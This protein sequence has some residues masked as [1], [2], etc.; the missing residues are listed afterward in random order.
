MNNPD[1]SPCLVVLTAPSG[2]GKTTIANQIMAKIPG[3]RFSVSATT[4]PRRP[5]EED[6]THYRFISHQEFQALIHSG[7][8]LEHEEVYPGRLY[9]TL[10][11]ELEGSSAE[12]PILLDI[13]IEGAFRIKKIYGENALI[14]FIRPPSLRELERRLK[15][16]ATEN[17]ETIR[18]RLERARKELEAA[19]R[20]ADKVIENDDIERAV[21]ETLRV[22]RRFI[23]R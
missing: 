6:G 9:G 10:R 17:E 7:E 1:Q 14:I 19:V 12:Q 5:D 18:I 23:K 15:D 4:R 22:V 21:K 8:M 20:Q 11:S 3:F 16:R 2:S 13:D